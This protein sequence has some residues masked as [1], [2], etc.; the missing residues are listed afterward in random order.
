M[1]KLFILSLLWVCSLG[2]ALAQQSLKGKIVDSRTDEP[3]I[4]AAILI[5]GTQTGTITDENGSFNLAL[6]SDSKQLEISYL[7][8]QTRIIPVGSLP[9]SGLIALEPSALELAEVM[10]VGFE[11]NRSLLES[12]GAIA[13]AGPRDFER[14]DKT[15][16]TQMLNQIPGVQARG[17]NVLRP[18]TISIRGQGAR[19]PGQTGRIKIYLN[20]LMLTNAD[21]T[22]AWEDI[23]PFTIGSIEVIKGPGS[24]IYGASVGGVLNIK[25]QAAPFGEESLEAFSLVGSYNSLRVGTTYRLS[26]DK[27]NL[28]AS[29]G[30]HSTDGFRTHSQ[31]QRDFMTFL[32]TFQGGS[33]H[34]TTVFFN[35]NRYD[36]RAPGTLTAEQAEEDPRQAL[37]LAITQ[38]AG[39]I[40]T[41]TRLG[42]SNEWQIS[43][44][45]RNITSLTTSFS[46]LD[47]PINF[48][49]IYQWNQNVGGRTRFIHDTRVFGKKSSFTL[50]GEYLTGVVKTNFYGIQEGKPT[51]RVTGDR[52][53]K[54]KN[55]I[56]FG[57]AEMELS[58]ELLV[59]AG[60]SVNFYEYGN[61]E[62]TLPGTTRQLRKFDPFVA[63]RIAFN[64]RP[65]KNVAIHGNVSTGFTPPATGDINR[66]DGT[67]NL[68]LREE[69]ALNFELGSRGS[70]LKGWLEYDLSV[71]RM[72]LTGEILTR[73]PEIGF[74]IR[75]N[76]GETSYTGFE[77]FLKSN[78]AKGSKGWIT[79]V[80]PSLGVTIQETVFVD[81]RESFAQQGQ[82]IETDLAGKSV[83]GNA[84]SRIFSNLELGAKNGIYLFGN[85][86]WVDRTPINNANTLFNEAFTFIGAKAGWR[87]YLSPRFEANVYVGVNNL[88]DEIYSDSPALNP[89]PIPA[90]PLAGQ[91]PYLNLNWG[92]NYYSGLHLK[93]HF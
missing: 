16:L 43:D 33:K 8:Y 55:G 45:W 90:G 30:T 72:N 51:G 18:A 12:T 3:I 92:R 34:T 42:I 32:A 53:A 68:D 35:R 69:T 23:D 17:S 24:S 48:L 50:G 46:D 6:T 57:Q 40:A 11:N 2:A 4:G 26:N 75:E 14:A 73:T 61:L 47:H 79:T 65:L 93:Y 37:P 20:D 19:G 41:F 89:N 70:I 25:T 64:Y 66:P 54:V 84:P 82:I 80:L 67:V 85:V 52:E 59:T 38:N 77:A 91:V 81:F 88:L 27:I 28:M 74:A 86:E 9:D 56:L 63:P 21:G 22:N 58:S 31:E 10:V 13:V 71:Y 62:L 87:G 29:V 49:Y 78:L 44:R 39:R 60:M 7:G 83:P 15:S 1:K 5:K 36:S 76:A